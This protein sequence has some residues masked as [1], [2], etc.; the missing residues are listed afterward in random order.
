MRGDLQLLLRLARSPAPGDRPLADAELIGALT[1]LAQEPD[2]E[3]VPLI[4]LAHRGARSGGL[5]ERLDDEARQQLSRRRLEL[6]AH[7]TQQRKLV[8]SLVEDLAEAG[9][10]AVLLKGAGF[11]RALYPADAPR[12]GGDIDLLVADRDFERACEAAAGVARPAKPRRGRRASH[13]QGYERCFVTDGPL[14]ALIEVHRGLTVPHVFSIDHDQLIARSRPHPAYGSEAVRI[15][16]PVDTLLH[17]AVHAFRHL[18]VETH[19]LLDAHEVLV[20]WN[21]DLGA[22]LDRSA[23]CGARGALFHLLR[24]ARQIGG[25]PVPEA[26]QAALEP[27][28]LRERAGRLLYGFATDRGLGLEDRAYRLTQLVSFFAVPDRRLGALRYVG[29]YAGW[30]ARDLLQAIPSS[31]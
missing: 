26:L 27:G 24:A 23:T 17:L 4:P 30:R 20:Q 31:S 25:S 10:T 2:P 29:R 3:L 7:A 28:V 16:D 5:L 22:L 1:R 18:R 13:A 15:L 21:P 12:I 14:G 19:A 9:I 11:D 8:A 6:V